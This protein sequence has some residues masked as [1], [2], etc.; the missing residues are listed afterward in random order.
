MEI[1]FPSNIKCISCNSIIPKT[2]AYSLCKGCFKKVNFLQSNC[3]IC[4]AASS[5]D[6]CEACKEDEKE[7]TGLI[8]EIYA[9]T[10]YEDEIKHM[11]H[12]FKYSSLTYLGN[13]FAEMLKDKYCSSKL[14]ADYII[15]IPS[16][17]SRIKQR[18][19]NHTDILAN[20]LSK[21]INIPYIKPLTKIK[22]TKPLAR[23][24]PLERFLEINGAFEISDKTNNLDYKRILLID[25][26]LTTGTTAIEISKLLKEGFS[27]IK[28]YFLVLATAKK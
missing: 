17:K 10:T 12:G 16:S 19:Y 8:D 11:I 7:H 20:S 6:I 5:E 3:I 18:G 15:T 25:D 9:C 21:K 24:N 22:D 28:I 14:N 23:L 2:N 13:E 27:N 26:I 1:L 4:G